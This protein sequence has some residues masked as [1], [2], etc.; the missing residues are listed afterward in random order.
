MTEGAVVMSQAVTIGH[1]PGPW[2]ASKDDS[3]RVSI[4][5]ANGQAIALMSGTTSFARQ[6]DANAALLAAAPELL[7][8]SKALIEVLDQQGVRKVALEMRVPLYERA[9]D[10]IDAIAK[11]ESKQP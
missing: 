9:A 6:R 3:R 8:A 7:A 1:S 10:L 11:A 4:R 2:R 5:A